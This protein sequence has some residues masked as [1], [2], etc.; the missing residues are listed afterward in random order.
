MVTFLFCHYVSP[1]F[2]FCTVARFEAPCSAAKA[3]PSYF[4]GASMVEQ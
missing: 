1:P 4:L 3:S 2:A